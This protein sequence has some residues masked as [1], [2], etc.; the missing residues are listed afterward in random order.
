[1]RTKFDWETRPIGGAVDFGAELKAVGLV[2]KDAIF[3]SFRGGG[4]CL[5]AGGY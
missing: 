1:M 5:R 2:L 4:G 3:E